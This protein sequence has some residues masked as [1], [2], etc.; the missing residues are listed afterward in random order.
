MIGILDSGFGGLQTLKYFQQLYPDFDFLFLADNKFSPYGE[1]FEGWIKERT[2]VMLEK[3]FDMWAVIVILACNTAAAVAV[4]AWQMQYP[5]KKVL[6]V[7]LPGVEKAKELL[8]MW[9]IYNIW[10][11]STQATYNSDVYV[12]WFQKVVSDDYQLESVAAGEIVLAIEN[13]NLPEEE[14][15][16][17]IRK[18]IDRFDSVKDCLILWCTHFPV[19]LQDFKSEFAGEIID[20]NW[21]SAV[22]IEKY[23]YNH[24]D[25]LWQISKHWYIKIWITWDVDSFVEVGKKIF[26]WLGNESVA[27]LDL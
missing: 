1:K 11:L 26:V 4:R 22:A 10:V 5:H 25:I 14:C 27:W 12:S 20:P 16:N 15:K 13:G 2:F 9:K 3:L 21:E 6:S 23:L 18:Y 24:L 19:W 17:M 8:A 7:T